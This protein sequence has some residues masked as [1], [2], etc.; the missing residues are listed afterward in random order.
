[1]RLTYILLCIALFTGCNGNGGP[2]DGGDGTAV[3]WIAVLELN[4]FNMEIP[5][6]W[7]RSVQA[8]FSEELHRKRTLP[9]HTHLF[10]QLELTEGPCSVYAP[11]YN[12]RWV[13]DPPCEPTQECVVDSDDQEVCKDLPYAYDL[14]P[15]TIQGLKI[16]G[17]MT[18]DEYRRY[19]IANT[20][21]DLFDDDDTITA[22]AP[23]G[24]LG[25]FELTVSG[26]AHLEVPDNQV[27]LQPGQAATLGWTAA[28]PDSRIM[29]VLA[30]GHHFPSLPT[31]YLT[32]DAQ[33]SDGQ[34]EIPAAIVDAFLALP[35]FMQN[36]SFIARYQ[37]A[38]ST[39]FGGE[40]E[41]MAASFQ[42]LQLFL[43]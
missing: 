32:C 6:D 1:M 8:Y 13:C 19:S 4:N 7:E 21:D 40:I 14:G 36:P 33:D 27:D 10:L 2:S 20:P 5:S 30:L 18:F 16:G 26:V 41:M 15:M 22:S 3:G 24:E 42:R 17:G 12:R 37:R 43:P 31:A 28:D 38:T 23:G 35:T 34:L 11:D 39:P 29:M 25:P 9:Y